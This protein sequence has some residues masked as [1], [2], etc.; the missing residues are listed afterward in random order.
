M[1]INSRIF[2]LY[3]AVSFA[4]VN[5]SYAQT[6][7]PDALIL[8]DTAFQNGNSKEAAERYK[9]Y[10]S[11][12]DNPAQKP[13]LAIRGMVKRHLVI[14]KHSRNRLKKDARIEILK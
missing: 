5:M 8:G 14:C 1:N 13:A 12:S 6:G 4:I 9:E 2:I 11:S 3:L 7:L 10:L